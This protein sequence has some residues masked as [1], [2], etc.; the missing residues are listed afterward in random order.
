MVVFLFLA[1]NCGQPLK[2]GKIYYYDLYCKAP[3]LV[4]LTECQN[5]RG[6]DYITGDNKIFEVGQVAEVDEFL[7]RSYLE[8]GICK[9]GHLDT[10]KVFRVVTR[11]IK[12]ESQYI[13]Y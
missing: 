2:E 4:A 6:G 7:E 9:E 8:N 10:S 5:V 1:L 12:D 13:K 3:A 11:Q